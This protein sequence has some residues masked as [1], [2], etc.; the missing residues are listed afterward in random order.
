MTMIINARV[1]NNWPKKKSKLAT[2]EQCADAVKSI[3]SPSDQQNYNFALKSF[4]MG[5]F[6]LSIF[7]LFHLNCV[8]KMEKDER[9]STHASPVHE[10]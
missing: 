5:I 8:G 3:L 1:V 7:L 6:F 9:D 2:W 10:N 4:L